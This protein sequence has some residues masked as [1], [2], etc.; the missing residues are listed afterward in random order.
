MHAGDRLP[1]VHL[2]SPMADAVATISAKGFGC[3]LVVDD[4]GMLAGIVTVG[5]LRRHMAADLLDQRVEAIMTPRPTAI[6]PD[7]LVAEAL[8][9]VESRKIAA[10]PV[11]EDGKPA[12]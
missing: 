12:L 6:P 7:T 3:V 8:E 1:L 9:M 4:R 11:V 2:G 10:L 5:D